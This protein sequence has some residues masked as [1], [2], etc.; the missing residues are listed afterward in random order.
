LERQLQNRQVRAIRRRRINLVTTIVGSLVVIGL[1]VWLVVAFGHSSSPS[2]SATGTA[3]PT[4]SNTP[5]GT[6]AASA[7]PTA[8]TSYPSAT[9]APITF[10]GVT[11]TGATDLKGMPVTT[12]K[13]TTDVSKLRVKDLVVGTGTAANPASDVT[14]QY[15]VVQYGDGTYL[16]SSWKA[17]APWE[18]SLA[19][20]GADTGMAGF[21]QGIGGGSGISPMRVGGRRIIII[22]SSMGFGT[23]TDAPVPPN[24]ALVFVIDLLEVGAT[25]TATPTPSQ[26]YPDATGAPVSFEGVTV[27][28]ATDLTG[29]PGVTS[30]SATDASTLDVKDLVVGTGDAATPTSQVT[31][32]YYGVLYK[33]GTYFDSSWKRGKPTDFSLTGVVPGFT[34]GIGGGAGVDPMRVGGRRIIIVPAS[35][36]YGNSTSAPIPPNSSLVFVVDLL[37]VS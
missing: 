31:V 36:G 30:S 32:Q 9:G 15:Y 26:S 22:P 5:G 10:D 3:A 18:T 25:S 35:L 28:G 14:V 27:T 33:D 7:T 12:S 21:S 17:G 24:T 29:M 2:A 13:G 16:D 34:Q 20:Y 8:S 19:D 11:V 23:A 6:D 1:V 37:K 4:A